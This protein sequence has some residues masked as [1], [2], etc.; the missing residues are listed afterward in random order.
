MAFF[1]VQNLPVD[2]RS[3]RAL[4]GEAAIERASDGIVVV[5]DSRC[6][7]HELHEHERES[8]SVGPLWVFLEGHLKACAHPEV[9][10]GM[11]G[12]RLIAE[13]L[14]DC[15]ARSNL[16]E[17]HGHFV[18]L[19]VEPRIRRITLIRDRLG[20]R[21]GF[22]STNSDV[23]AIA[24]QSHLVTQLPG[25][26]RLEDP[27]YIASMFNLVNEPPQG[28]SPFLGVQ[29][30]RP[31]ERLEFNNRMLS[32]H[33]RNWPGNISE[34]P[35]RPDD[36][37]EAFRVRFTRAVES[38][39]SDGDNACIML[40]GG[41]DS[42]PAAA[43]AAAKQKK[44][45]KTL[46]AISFR[47]KSFPEANESTYIEKTAQHI[48]ADLFMFD[49]DS[50][51]SFEN[52]DRSISQPDT[53]LLNFYRPCINRCY[54]IAG[55]RGYNVILNGHAGDDLYPMSSWV[56]ADALRR[57]DLPQAGM[58]FREAIQKCGL[59]S[60][61]R[62]PAI[63]TVLSR[64]LKRQ[65]SATT[66]ANAW[67][68]DKA[69]QS[70]YS[71]RLPQEILGHPF[72]AYAKKLLGTR[73]SMGTAYENTITARYGLERRD[74]FIDESLI[75]L[76]LE[77]PFSLSHREGTTKWIMREAM[78]KGSYLPEEIRLKRR[79]GLLTEFLDASFE[80]SRRQI[81]DFLFREHTEWQE[82]IDPA[83]VQRAVSDHQESYRDRALAAVSIGYCLWLDEIKRLP[84]IKPS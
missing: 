71:E 8:G 27:S 57:M 37:I 30:L 4:L 48:G 75:E 65:R 31:G 28:R 64:T 16:G 7:Y 83:P 38:C 78:K 10:N 14:R 47:F 59:K 55:N 19:I 22:Y 17:L 44:Y 11:S 18:S 69:A 42:S 40:S 34:P 52:I 76:A 13:R 73:I 61:H 3:F 51:F 32:R 5:A 68:T 54:E 81:T 80:V 23:L 70:L 39:V 21:T 46:G 45:G 20:A 77:M 6:Q 41:L 36:W 66:L 82:W 84:A 26:Q 79:T 43:I 53:P 62:S 60:I 2:A 49:A 1:L 58:Q 29:E 25:F 56:L 72:P 24:S 63:R 35:D 50:L 12:A 33:A 74:P 67:L 9:A 15:N